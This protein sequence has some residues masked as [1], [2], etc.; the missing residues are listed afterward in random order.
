MIDKVFLLNSST[1]KKL[2]RFAKNLPIIDYH[3]HLSLN[4]IKT[5]KRFTDVYELWVEADPYKHRAMRMCGVSERYITGDASHEEKFVKWCEVIPLLIGN[6]LYFWSLMEL[7]TIFGVS[8][9]P[10]RENALDIYRLCNKYLA[11][12][13][14]TVNKMLDDFNVELA[15]PCVSITDDISF[16]EN[17]SRFSPSLRADDMLNP[18]KDFIK[19]LEKCS[20]TSIKDL[21]AFKCA[22]SKRLDYFQEHGCVFADHAI[23]NG[24]RFFDDDGLNDQRFVSLMENG[25]DKENKEK[26]SIH[27][28]LYLGQ[29]YAKR[30]FVMQLHIGAER[31]TSTSLRNMVG[32]AG[33]FAGIGNSVDICSLVKL[34]DTLDFSENGLPKTVLFTLNPADN[35]S[36]SV[37]SGSFS[38]D[39]V[40]GLITQGPAWWWC[41]H[42]T[43]I[44]EMLEATAAYS[45]L[46]NFIG[47]TTDSRSFLSF[48]R[49]DYFRR[50]LCNWLGDKVKK[51]E[52]PCYEKQLKN[53]IMNLCYGNAKAEVK[54]RRLLK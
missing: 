32:P 17:S 28:L 31:Y 50:I 47:M 22:I 42:K 46:S 54:S 2:Y 3:N 34:L 13:I 29:E 30:R 27:I 12:N 45:V 36:M 19:K 14:I 11:D 43:G 24:F 39:G 7:K 1:A 40:N 10:D 44:E 25:L 35:A 5:N 9:L 18:T 16:L 51:S 52:L 53:L 23:D 38:K 26:F 8:Q 41:D 49:H 37:L 15:C 33:G 6:P 21:K 4:E 20:Q 48:V